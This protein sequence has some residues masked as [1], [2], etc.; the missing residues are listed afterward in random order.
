MKVI[1]NYCCI[2]D[3]F[4]LRQYGVLKQ[5]AAGLRY[6]SICLEICAVDF[7]RY[8]RI[9]SAAAQHLGFRLQNSG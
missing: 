2:A 9:G 3:R 7:W 1:L 6:A 5:G 4:I 8:A